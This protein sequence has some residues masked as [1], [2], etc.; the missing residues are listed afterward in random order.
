MSTTR[1]IDPQL[2]ARALDLCRER[3][4]AS[5]SNFA[6]AFSPLPRPRREGI[7][8][9]YA[10]CRWLDDLVDEPQENLDPRAELDAWRAAVPRALRGEVDDQD[11]PVLVGVAATHERF[12]LHE[13]D[14][15]AVIDGMQ[16][17]LERNR[18]ETAEELSLY[19]RR[20]AGHV[21]CLCLPVFGSQSEEGRRF[22]M[23]L[24]EAFQ[25]TNIL[26]DVG[27]DA[28]QGRIYLPLEEL[29]R[30]GVTPEEILERRASPRLA[31][32]LRRMGERA[33]RL[34]NLAEQALPTNERATLF[35]ASIMAAIYRRLLEEVQGR[36]PDPFGPRPRLPGRLKGLLATGVILRD[37]VFRLA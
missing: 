28:A 31:A 24:G 18:Y 34:F 30:A 35:S 29:E 37:A 23:K 13:V 8:A 10:Y 21:G 22:A 1:R 25:M 2:T 32:L 12:G 17:D 36:A 33:L 15:L 27:G 20:V 6:L 11:D 9:V 26:R 14:L 16:M 7:H 3:T 4:R 5:K 19:C